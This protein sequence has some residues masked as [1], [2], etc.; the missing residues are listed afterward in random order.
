MPTDQYCSGLGHLRCPA[1]NNGCN[2]LRLDQVRR[3]CEHIQCSEWPATH[4]VY[5]AQCIG[6]RDLT[7]SKWVI[8]D[9]C[10]KIDRLNQRHILTKSI[11][12]R[13]IGGVYA[14]Q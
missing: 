5:I 9:G 13:V 12:R 8:D 2:D 7:I 3:K 11:H 6:G 10:E 14:N 4:G 1:T